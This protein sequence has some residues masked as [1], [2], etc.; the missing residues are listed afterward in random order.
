MLYFAWLFAEVTT[1]L[2]LLPFFILLAGVGAL[3]LGLLPR[4]E[5]V[6]VVAIL[7]VLVAWVAL[8]VLA[9]LG[10]LPAAATLSAWGPPALLPLGLQV[11]VDPL[12]WVFGMALLTATL[13]TLLTSVARPGGRRLAVRGAMLLLTFAGLAALLSDNL[14]TIILA[15]GGLDLIYFL[16]LVLLGQSDGLEL[17]AVLNLGFNVAGTLLAA[18]AALLIS[19]ESAALSLRDAA[20][21]SSSTLLITLAAMFRLGLFPLHLA[22]PAEANIRQGLGTVLRL[23]PAAVAL[24]VMARLALYGFTPMARLGLTVLALAAALVGAAQLWRIET[25]PLGITYF[26]VAESGL[27][28]L[29]GLWSGGLALT[30]QSVAMVLGGALIFLFSG[31]EPRRPWLTALPVLGVLGVVGVPLTAGY[32]GAGGLLEALVAGR[33]W[34]IVAGMVAAQILLAMGLFRVAFWPGELADEAPLAVAAYVGGL[35][36][37]VAGLVLAGWPGAAWLRTALGP[38]GAAPGVWALLTVA[39]VLAAGLGLWRL[40]TAARGPANVAVEAL[41]ALFRLDWLYRLVWGTVHLAGTLIFN[42][43]AVLEGEGAV[44]WVLAAILLIVLA[45]K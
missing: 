40:E 6:E 2:P 24:E 25:P 8:G 22:L 32:L 15:W 7:A 37:P 43:A 11:V 18:G 1:V 3:A 34:L 12:S 5:R 45:L 27:A 23:V 30:A 13:A 26:V 33:Q 39:A 21:T 4:F 17:Q 9:P 16:V 35:A 38:G 44:L 14:L 10:Q 42:L 19:R 20:L 41:S 29:A 31:H 36:L 28:L